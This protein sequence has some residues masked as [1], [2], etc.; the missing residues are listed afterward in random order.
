[1]IVYSFRQFDLDFCFTDTISFHDVGSSSY[2]LFD[3]MMRHEK[4]HGMRAI[5]MN[6]V[7][8]GDLDQVSL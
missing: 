5:R 3:Y 4:M 7:A 2:Q 1:M 6:H 8:E